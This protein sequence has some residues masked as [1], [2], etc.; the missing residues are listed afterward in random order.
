[1]NNK[2]S[3]IVLIA[4]MAITLVICGF[5]YLGG[6]ESVPTTAGDTD[7]PVYTSMMISWAYVL[8][9]I[10]AVATLAFAILVF[11]SKAS[12]NPKSVIVPLITTLVLGVLLLATYFGADT[13]PI[14]IIGYEGSHEPSIYR[15]TNMCITSAVVLAAVATF[16]TL[17]GFL[18][19]KF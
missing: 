15:L 1:M 10:A 16:V 2:I 4:L 3:S 12:Y 17:F 7:A 6:E 18:A 8:I 11:I 14:S 9:I 19:K 13:T 5:F